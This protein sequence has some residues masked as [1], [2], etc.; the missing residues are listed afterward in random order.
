MSNVREQD[1]RERIAQGT[2]ARFGYVVETTG[3]PEMA[4]LAAGGC[5]HEG[6]QG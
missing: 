6:P 1:V 5:R 3:R 2:G 4:A